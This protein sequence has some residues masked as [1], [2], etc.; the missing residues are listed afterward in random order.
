M[1]SLLSL[2]L[3]IVIRILGQLDVAALENVSRSSPIFEEIVNDSEIWRTQFKRQFGVTEFSSLTR[4]KNFSEEFFARS[5]M[6]RRWARDT[7]ITKII[8]VATFPYAMLCDV[9]MVYPRCFVKDASDIITVVNVSKGKM[10]AQ[11]S[12][13]SLNGLT[14][15]CLSPTDSVVGTINGVIARHQ[16]QQRF[17]YANDKPFD[18]KH[19]SKVTCIY[20]NETHCYSGDDKG[21]IFVSDFK[22]MKVEHEYKLNGSVQ[23]LKGCRDSVIAVT[24]TD[25]HVLCSSRGTSVI[26]F[27]EYVDFFKVDFEGEVIIVGHETQLWAYS[28]ASSSFG[29]S[30]SFKVN[31]SDHITGVSLETRKPCD[32]RVAGGDGLNLAV[33]TDNRLLIFNIRRGLDKPLTDIMPTLDTKRGFRINSVAVNATV[34]LVGCSDGLIGCFEVLT[35][36]RLCIINKALPMRYF[37]VRDVSTSHIFLGGS[38]DDTFGGAIVG[39]IMIYFQVGDLKVPA[40]K[41]KGKKSVNGLI[42][43]R[44]N[45]IH[46]VIK[47]EVDEIDY[48]HQLQDAEDELRSRYN[49]DDLTQEEEIELA[50]VLNQSMQEQSIDNESVSSLTDSIL[51]QIISDSTEPDIES[52]EP[53]NSSAHHFDD[54]YNDEEFERH[55]EEALRRSVLDN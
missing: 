32:A 53:T 50:M 55:L 54:D 31:G 22:T 39:N 7:K 18:K 48:R 21:N 27:D 1:V 37:G 19:P 38:N 2:P 45:A 42:G 9:K 6:I 35:G 4:S 24:K 8:K 44:K 17:Y 5:Q 33:V 49:G 13:S 15:Q 25:M 12:A 51:E 10:E 3:E 14:T 29:R 36:R 26:P 16:L 23:C 20:S 28:F 34:A 52:T 30:T 43:E 46:K 41:K 47:N 40:S 11:L